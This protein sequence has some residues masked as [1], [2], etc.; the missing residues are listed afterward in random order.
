[1]ATS[2]TRD[3]LLAV[4]DEQIVCAESMLSTLDSENEALLQGDTERLNSV[5]AG[6]ARLSE[7]LERLEGERRDLSEALALSHESAGND[8]AGG[9]WQRLLEVL[10]QCRDRNVRNGSLVQ[11]RRTQIEAVLKA[12]VSTQPA[13]YDATGTQLSRNASQ[14]LGTA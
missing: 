2:G 8:A 11:A 12:L 4:I 14:R 13:S 7:Q 1:M 3:H 6:K 10:E 9:R 5:S